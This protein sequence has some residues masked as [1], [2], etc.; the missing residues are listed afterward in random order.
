MPDYL[1]T[2]FTE[3]DTLLLISTFTFV[4]G[5]F[6]ARNESLLLATKK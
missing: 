4:I 3:I 1:N 5:L 2:F 6:L